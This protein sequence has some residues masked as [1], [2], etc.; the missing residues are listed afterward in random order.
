VVELLPLH[1]FC[2]VCGIAGLFFLGIRSR[3]WVRAG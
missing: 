3:F 1:A 2:I